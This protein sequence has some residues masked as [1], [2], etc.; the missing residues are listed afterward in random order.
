MIAALAIL[1]ILGIVGL[2]IDLQLV[3]TRKNTV[4]QTL[5]ATL[6]A[7]AR[8]AQ[9]GLNAADVSEEANDFFEALLELNAPGVDCG[10]VI[11]SSSE[12]SEQINATVDCKQP[13]TI[14]SIFPGRDNFDFRVTSGSTFGVGRVDIAF[15]F[16]LSES[17]NQSGRLRALRDAADEA[18]D[19]LLQANT[20]S[21]ENVRIA[22]S[23]YN[24]S[25]NV[26]SFYDSVVDFNRRS[27]TLETSEDVGDLYPDNIGVVQVDARDNRQFWDFETV[28]CNRG[29][30]RNCTRHDDFAAR[31]YPQVE[32]S[33]VYARQ[34]SDAFTDAVPGEDSYMIADKPLWDYGDNRNDSNRP[35]DFNMKRRGQAEILSEGYGRYRD[36]RESRTNPPLRTAGGNSNDAPSSAADNRFGNNNSTDNN[37]LTFHA[38]IRDKVPNQAERD[39]ISNDRRLDGCA[40]TGEVLPLTDS[41]TTLK[42]YTRDMRAEGATAGHLGIAW[43]WYLLSPKWRS[44]WPNAS[45]P[46]DYFQEDT[47]KAMIIMTD[48]VFNATHPNTPEN[49]NEMAAEYC[50]A[51]KRDTNIRIYTIGFDVPTRTEDVDGVEVRVPNLPF[52]EGTNQ[53]I[54]E[55]CAS[56]E[57]T[58][59]DA[60]GQQELTDAYTQ[61]AVEISDL[62]LAQ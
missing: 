5:D 45:E 47:A 13:T 24:H 33:C 16:D 30:N 20:S 56:D 42:N 25:V 22:I 9:A 3:V 40:E 51:I 41:E 7:A 50:R 48:G 62:R 6:I 14:S 53:N 32:T 43:G 10:R 4:Q 17:M 57:D 31:F 52:V 23:A 49:S 35:D 27:L 34:G 58:A 1:P 8:D 2:A 29:N 12:G 38:R 55:F 60:S 19:I 11:T 59:F 61:I 37:S 46:L 36:G 54:L 15:V 18:I 28:D 26:G 44:I 39:F 21:A